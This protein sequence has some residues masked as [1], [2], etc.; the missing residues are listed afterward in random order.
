MG[1]MT[2]TK[3]GR[4]GITREDVMKARVLHVA[5]VRPMRYVGQDERGVPIEKIHTLSDD[6]GAM[7]LQ[8]LGGIAGDWQPQPCRFYYPQKP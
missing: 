2:K 7:A 4:V 6:D 8:A 5:G 1:R 3:H